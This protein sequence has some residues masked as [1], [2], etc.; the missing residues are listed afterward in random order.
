MTGLLR[1]EGKKMKLE[2]KIEATFTKNISKIKGR[3]LCRKNE[4]WV[5]GDKRKNLLTDVLSG[6][7]ISNGAVNFSK[8]KKI[9]ERLFDVY[10][11]VKTKNYIKASCKIY[12][13]NYEVHF[14]DIYFLCKET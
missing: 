4:H 14:V 8:W 9:K 5:I 3:A 11:L 1:G 10:L 7:I 12:S 6:R 2:A 13:L